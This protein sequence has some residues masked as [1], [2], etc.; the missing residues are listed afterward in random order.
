[1]QRYHKD[2]TAPKYDGTVFVFGSNKEGVHG[3]GAAL[4]AKI[5]FDAEQGKWDGHVGR[6]Y[7]IPTKHSPRVSMMPAEIQPYVDKFLDYA[8]KHRSIKFFVTRIGCGL[9]GMTDDQIAPGQLCEPRR[10]S[11]VSRV[12]L[13]LHG[14]SFDR[15][16]CRDVSREVPETRRYTPRNVQ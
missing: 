16:L 4:F 3:K 2:G 6:S 14:R 8:S 1:M 13:Q 11:L 15:A 9:A 12:R 10:L 7:A 5:H